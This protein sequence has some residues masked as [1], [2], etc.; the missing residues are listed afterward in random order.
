[1]KRINT[2]IDSNGVSPAVGV[3]LM[4]AVGV[5]AFALLTGLGGTTAPANSDD[6]TYEN[7]E[8]STF[9]VDDGLVTV[10]HFN[11]STDQI[12]VKNST[13]GEVIDTVDSEGEMVDIR[14]EGKVSFVAVEKITDDEHFVRTFES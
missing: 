14:D 11:D 12:V 6:P 8:E 5:I 9:I 13:T 2:S 7:A 4:V 10:N 3:I 1:M